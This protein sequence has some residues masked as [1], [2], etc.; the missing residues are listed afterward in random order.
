MLKPSLFALQEVATGLMAGAK[1]LTDLRDVINRVRADLT[2]DRQDN[3]LSS[4]ADI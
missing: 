2:D 3:A 1:G 4:V